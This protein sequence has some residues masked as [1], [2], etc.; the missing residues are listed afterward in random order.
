MTD[1]RSDIG[2]M[3]AKADQPIDI[4]RLRRKTRRLVRKHR[5]KISRVALA[6]LERSTLQGEEI[7]ALI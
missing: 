4:E 6:L 7:D 3:C 5:D 2:F 1:D